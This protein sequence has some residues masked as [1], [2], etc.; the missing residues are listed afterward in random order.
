ML[1]GI[2][3]YVLLLYFLNSYLDQLS[4]KTYKYGQTLNNS[5]VKIRYET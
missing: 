3:V 2:N 1:Y 4:R 5:V